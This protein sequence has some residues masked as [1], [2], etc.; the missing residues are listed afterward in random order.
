M[1]DFQI[2]IKFKFL[3]KFKFKFKKSLNLN[4]WVEIQ[5]TYQDLKIRWRVF[6][7]QGASKNTLSH[8]YLKSEHCSVAK[9]CV[10]WLVNFSILE[11]GHRI[12]VVL[13]W[14]YILTTSGG[15]TKL[16]M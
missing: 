8:I 13:V 12:G 2:Q 14:H 7:C 1:S 10:K 6:Q 3:K 5:F 4:P 16:C 9:N 11:R 15:Y